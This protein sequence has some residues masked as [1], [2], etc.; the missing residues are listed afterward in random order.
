VPNQSEWKEVECTPASEGEITFHF[1][2][3]ER[4]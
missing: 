3:L 1:I 2:T 4:K